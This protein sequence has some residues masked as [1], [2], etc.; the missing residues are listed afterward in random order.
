MKRAEADGCAGIE[1][2]RTADGDGT[3]ARD[4][5]IRRFQPQVAV[6]I[7]IV[8][9]GGAADQAGIAAYLDVRNSHRAGSDH[10]HIAP[11]QPGGIHRAATD[12]D[13]V[14]R[15]HEAECDRRTGIDRHALICRSIGTRRGDI[16]A[17]DR[18]TGCQADARSD[19]PVEG[20]ARARV[21]PQR[22]ARF[23]RSD[24]GRRIGCQ[25]D[26]PAD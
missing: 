14:I 3:R 7:A 6:D 19:Q 18:G 25:R 5:A 4:A 23:D 12:H 17:K 26:G 20:Q 10:P 11:E 2:D 16:S 24:G 21:D 22:T 15:L 1:V 8:E 13:V 9:Q